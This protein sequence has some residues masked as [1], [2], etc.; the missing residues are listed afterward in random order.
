MTNYVQPSFPSV[1]SQNTE[2]V[3]KLDKDLGL[4]LTEWSSNIKRILDGGIS[5][6]D[7]V[8]CAFVT[9]TSHAV[10]G[11][12]FTVPHTLGKVPVGYIVYGQS[13]A[14][15]VYDGVTTNT[16][17]TLYL[18]SDVSAITFRLVVF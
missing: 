15:S 17:T 9:F 6:Q 18:K 2:Q 11:T 16:K 12:E 10:A 4:V 1:F 7:N 5:F 13:G 8:D 3:R 14:G